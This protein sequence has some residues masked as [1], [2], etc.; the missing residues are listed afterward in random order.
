MNKLL[1]AA[2][3]AAALVSSPAGAEPTATIVGFGGVEG[4]CGKWVASAEMSNLDVGFSSWLIGYVSGLNAYGAAK[5]YSGDLM[6]GYDGNSLVPWAKQ[7]CRA[8][9]LDQTSAAGDALF[10]E[11]MHRVGK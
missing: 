4:G 6:K 5:G 11:L 7:W 1:A 8:H 9:P 10:F 2:A 3:V